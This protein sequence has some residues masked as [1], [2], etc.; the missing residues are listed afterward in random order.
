[1]K[2]LSFGSINID[3]VYT[4]DH[5]VRPGETIKCD[6]YQIHCGGKGCNQ[7]IALAHAGA[8]VYHAGKIGIDGDWL[9]HR[10]EAHGVDTSL[11]EKTE[12]HTGHAIIQVNRQGENEIII[13]GGAN[14]SMTKAYITKALR[15]FA[16]GDYLLLQN[17][18]NNIADIITQ[19]AK[20]GLNVVLNPAPMDRSVLDCP[21]E[22]VR[23]FIVNEIEGQELTG[24]TAPDDILSDMGKKFPKAM[25]VLTLGKN[26]VLF[27][28]GYEKIKVPAQ[29]VD[30]VDTTAA[31]DTFIGF[32]L[33]DMMNNVD[34]ET[35]LTNACK[36]AALCA[37]KPGAVD[38]IP[39]RSAVESM[40]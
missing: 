11:I 5:F 35:A 4:I 25:I 29:P 37:T 26:G 39:K 20:A 1:M 31:G 8:T 3:H 28:N 21:L 10:M 16:K 7:S 40:K 6:S 17:E 9:I 14:Q 12:D 22:L 18:I 32:F 24:K 36:A 34:A 19:G 33:A 27:K 23:C 15:H 30:A 13:Y 2:I 38:A